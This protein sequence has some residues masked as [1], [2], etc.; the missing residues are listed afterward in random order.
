MATRVDER[1]LASGAAAVGPVATDRQLI[2]KLG[3]WPLFSSLHCRG[4]RL[5]RAIAPVILLA[6]LTI[7]LSISLDKLR[8]PQS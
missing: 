7:A 1:R 8:E 6:M 2:Y 5:G 4:G 3:S